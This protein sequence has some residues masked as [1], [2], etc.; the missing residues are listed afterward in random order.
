MY[1]GIFLKFSQF[2]KG[3]KENLNSG[4]NFNK[5]PGFCL[6]RQH[7][8]AAFKLLL[9]IPSLT[10][11]VYYLNEYCQSRWKFRN[12]KIEF[13]LKG[14]SGVKNYNNDSRRT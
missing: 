9:L 4:L 5:N 13:G 11:F 3:F 1:L 2:L 10:Y 8:A 14:K 7:I 6:K 12:N